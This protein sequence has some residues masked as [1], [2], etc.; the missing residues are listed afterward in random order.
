MILNMYVYH[1]KKLASY[2]LPV[3]DAKP[4]EAFKEEFIRSIKLGAKIPA[5]MRELDLY[6][7]GTFDDKTCKCDIHAPEFLTSIAEHLTKENIEDE[8]TSA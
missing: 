3:F 5:Q 6:Y 1:D 2:S 8:S 7:I 4:V